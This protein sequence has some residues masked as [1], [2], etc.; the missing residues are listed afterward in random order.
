MDA[1]GRKALASLI[2]RAVLAEAEATASGQNED[3]DAD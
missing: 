1:T 2:R 3:P